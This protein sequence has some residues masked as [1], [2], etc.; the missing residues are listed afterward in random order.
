MKAIIEKRDGVYMI[1][2]LNDDYKDVFVVD[3]LEVNYED[4]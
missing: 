3:E 4:I 2:F 1:T